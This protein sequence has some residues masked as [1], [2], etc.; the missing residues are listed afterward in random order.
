MV[1][2]A[3]WVIVCLGQRLVRF[4]KLFV[5]FSSCDAGAGPACVILCRRVC[6]WDGSPLHRSAFSCDWILGEWKHCSCTHTHTHTHTI[7]CRQI[8]LKQFPSQ[9]LLIILSCVPIAPPTGVKVHTACWTLLGRR[10]SDTLW[11]R[12]NPLTTS[13]CFRVMMSIG[14][15]MYILHLVDRLCAGRKGGT[16]VSCVSVGEY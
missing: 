10:V 8:S 2:V 13:D 1:M 3:K 6:Y 15:Y 14:A 7:I 9:W 5:F 12:F 16:R 11:V 4:L